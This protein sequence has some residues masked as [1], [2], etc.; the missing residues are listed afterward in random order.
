[1]GL[2]SEIHADV[3]WETTVVRIKIPGAG[4]VAHWVRTLVALGENSSLVSTIYMVALNHLTTV[5]GD[6]RL[7]SGLSGHCTCVPYVSTCKHTHINKQKKNRVLELYDLGSN[8]CF[9]SSWSH[10]IE[11]VSVFCPLISKV[12]GSRGFL[13]ELLVTE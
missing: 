1:M 2:L 12:D 7:S 8:F 3:V 10:D 5:P 13:L 9:V 4:E 11:L 6:P